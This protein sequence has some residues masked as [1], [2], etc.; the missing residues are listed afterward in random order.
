MHLVF[1]LWRFVRAFLVRRAVLVAENL[2]LRQQLALSLRD[3]PKP[4]L[5]RRDRL[6]WVVLSRWF[7]AWRDWLA[8]VQP[9][10]VLTWHRRGFRLFW[11]WKSGSV[12]PGRPKLAREVIGLIRRMAKDNVTWGAPRI[13]AELHLL[14]HDVAESTVARYMPKGRKPPSQT[15]KIFLRNHADCLASMDFFVVPTV[16]FKLVYAFVLLLHQRRRIVHL[17]TTTHPT[18]H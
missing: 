10:T 18:S 1:A 5:R 13:R 15:W 11:R 9:A 14:G 4:R 12:A 16:T 3:R 7:A 6:F 17:A 8:I 2:A